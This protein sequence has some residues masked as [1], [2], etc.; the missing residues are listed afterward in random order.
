MR[1]TSTAVVTPFFGKVAVVVA[2]I[3]RSA[4]VRL[5]PADVSA[6]ALAGG[7][8]TVG[9]GVG[10]GEGVGDAVGDA[11]GDGVGVGE[12]EGDGFADGVEEADAFGVGLA[13]A[14]GLAGAFFTGAFFT[15]FLTTFLATGFFAAIA[16]SPMKNAERTPASKVMNLRRPCEFDGLSMINR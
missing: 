7:A 14:T 1:V 13:F 9:D 8:T 5:R 4:V 6:C 15:G 2:P 12:L 3:A 11:V 10:V 16:F